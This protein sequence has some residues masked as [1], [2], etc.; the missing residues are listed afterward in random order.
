M[1]NDGVKKAEEMIVNLD[2]KSLSVKWSLLMNA[3]PIMEMPRGEAL[4]DT[5]NHIV[6]HRA[7]LG[8]YLRM[9][10]IPHPS[11]YGPSADER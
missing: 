6:H 10:D 7:Q 11:L 1:F 9:N 4:R 2:E 8:V 3:K 5:L